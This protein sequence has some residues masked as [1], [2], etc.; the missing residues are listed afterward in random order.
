MGLL[1]L[2]LGLLDKNACEIIL[3]I[4]AKSASATN[5]QPR[6]EE[7]PSAIEALKSSRCAVEC[8]GTGQDD[9]LDKPL[10]HDAAARSGKAVIATTTEQQEAAKVNSK[11][12]F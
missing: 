11:S 1:R 12:K 4:R 8:V 3:T 5:H 6:P 7:E 10:S 9:T 2:V